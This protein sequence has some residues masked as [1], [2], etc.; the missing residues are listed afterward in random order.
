MG[1]FRH[2]RTTQERR[3]ATALATD[4]REF[5]QDLGVAIRPRRG[6]GGSLVTAWDDIDVA[7]RTDRSW[8]R[9]RRTRWRL[10]HR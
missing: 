8:K 4:I 3:N 6:T 7:A 5:R 2:P 10:R 1:Y 9:H